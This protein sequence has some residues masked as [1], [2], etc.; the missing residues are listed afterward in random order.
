[1]CWL[2]VG[3]VMPVLIWYLTL[4]VLVL[5]VVFVGSLVCRW[6]G[7]FGD[8]A[9]LGIYCG[10]VVVVL[11]SVGVEFLLAGLLVLNLLFVFTLLI[12]VRFG[13]TIVWC[14]ISDFVFMLFQAVWVSLLV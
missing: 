1:M 13:F 3:F 14:F 10:I 6:F 4:L 5:V 7:V 2:L 9:G 12:V 8:F 11:N